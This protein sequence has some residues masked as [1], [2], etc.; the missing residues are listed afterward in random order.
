[1]PLATPR[2]FDD[3]GPL[4]LGHHSLPLEEYVVCGALAQGP[5]G[6]VKLSV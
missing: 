3:L 2:A 6:V 4:I 1:M 5:V